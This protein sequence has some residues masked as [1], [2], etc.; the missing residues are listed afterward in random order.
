MIVFTTA[1][2][3][4]KFSPEEAPQPAVVPPPPLQCLEG[5]T[6]WVPGGQGQQQCANACSDGSYLQCRTNLEKEIVCTGNA[7]V[8]SG[9]VRV[10]SVGSA[11]GSCPVPP[12]TKTVTD[13]FNAPPPGKADILV[14]MDTTPSMSPDLNKLSARFASLTKNLGDVDWQVA[15]TNAGASGGWLGTWDAQGEFFQFQ[16]HP[17]GKTILKK[18]DEDVDHYFQLTVG[19]K[20]DEVRYEGSQ[21][22]ANVCNFQP[23]CMSSHPKPLESLKKAIDLRKTK[24]A[25][26]FRSDAWLVPLMISDADEDEY[27]GAEA[28]QPKAL[29]D[30]FKATLGSSMKGVLGF[31]IVIKPGDNTCRGSQD[32][33]FSTGKFGTFVDKFANLT[34]GLTMSI[35]ENDY[36]KGLAQISERV[37]D[38]MVSIELTQEPVSD[39]IVVTVT[40]AVPGLTWKRD[41]RKILFSKALPANAKVRVVY[42]A[43]AN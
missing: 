27:G 36:S 34:G 37:R 38:R 24:N 25:G 43:K 12:S 39:D 32:S 41:G 22:T 42:R 35:C 8:E 5:E 31:G 7:M 20:D 3:S 33:F 19:S 2:N 11:I 23:Y 28:M 26:F 14:I 6:A 21:T 1:C 30:H 17:Q 18:S 10:G 9:N 29:V 16:D 40:P 4:V 13:D 15:V